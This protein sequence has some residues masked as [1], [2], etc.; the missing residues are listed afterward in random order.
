MGQTF[1]DIFGNV[2]DVEH[3]LIAQRRREFGVPLHAREQLDVAHRRD[4]RAL[5]FGREGAIDPFEQIR[6]RDADVL[7]R[8]AD[9]DTDRRPRKRNQ[10]RGD[11]AALGAK[12]IDETQRTAAA[13]QD[14][15]VRLVAQI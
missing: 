1:G 11:R 3:G 7:P 8:V 14:E 4:E 6:E 5:V 9:D 2:F 10:T 15:D 12:T 13:A